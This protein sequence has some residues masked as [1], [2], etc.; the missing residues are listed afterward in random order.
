MNKEGNFISHNY[1]VIYIEEH[2]FLETFGY[3]LLVP[4]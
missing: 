4:A 1:K 3:W 2:L